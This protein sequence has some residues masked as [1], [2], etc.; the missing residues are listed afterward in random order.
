MDPL[1]ERLKTP[2]DCEQFAKNV[3]GQ[4]P[5]LAKEARRH[6]VNLRSISYGANSEV[7]RQAIRCVLAFEEARSQE[8][9]KRAHASRTW[10]SIKK[11][12]IIPTV[13][14]VV[15]RRTSTDGYAALVDAGLEEYTFE[16][17]VLRF[18][19]SFSEEAVAQAA[20]R[21]K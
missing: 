6:A 1:V 7:E 8:T 11:N 20:A 2:E 19:E 10:Q 16:A 12:R 9:G 21:L 5:D 14:R 18:P 3:E 15:S 4:R 13:D 17:V